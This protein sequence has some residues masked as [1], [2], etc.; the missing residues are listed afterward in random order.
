MTLKTYTG[1]IIDFT[2]VDPKNIHLEDILWSLPRLNRFVGHSSRTY[3]VGEHTL[4]CYLMAQ[5]LGY[6]I[7][8][9]MLVFIHDF[10]EAYCNDCPA[11]LKRL[12]PDFEKYERNI[13]LAICK[14]FGI[15]PPTEEEHLKVKMIDLTMLVFEM[16][17]LTLHEWESFLNDYTYS[18]LLFESDFRINPRTAM[19][20][21]V[22]RGV[23]R[24]LFL[25]LMNQYKE[26]Y[27]DGDRN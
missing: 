14:S 24:T 7:R 9:Q 20:E 27:P 19:D 10:T 23:M 2:N 8:E 11:P 21:E 5:N 15:E 22:T 18:E 25:G 6:S 4:Y 3:S 1:N 12:I 26:E 17:D 16:R 13:E